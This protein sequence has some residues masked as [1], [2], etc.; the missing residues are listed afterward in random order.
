MGLSAPSVGVGEK[1]RE[2][3]HSDMFD[4]ISIDDLVPGLGFRLTHVRRIQGIG[5]DGLD[6]DVS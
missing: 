2:V 4:L 6:S 5:L 3:T 1:R